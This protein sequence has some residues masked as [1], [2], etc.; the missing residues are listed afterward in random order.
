V[1]CLVCN[2]PDRQVIEAEMARGKS[3]PLVARFYSIDANTLR[4]H[5]REHIHA[6]ALTTKIDPITIVQDLLS[7]KSELEYRLGM[8]LPKKDEKG[9]A[10]SEVTTKEYALLYPAW[11]KTVETIIKLT[12]AS[13]QRDPKD[14]LPLWNRM[15]TK[16]TEWAQK[17]PVEV[18]DDLYAMLE[19]IERE[20]G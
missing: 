13:V 4:R 20:A 9:N 8:G 1:S 18:R 19:E 6:L 2:H 17:Q 3:L 15:L 10:Y 16:M 5:K 7:G 12:G 11:L 14:L